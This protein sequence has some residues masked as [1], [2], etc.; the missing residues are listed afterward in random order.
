MQIPKELHPFSV[1]TMIVVTDNVHAKY[2]LAS[3]REID[4]IN[5]V[6]TKTDE[7]EQEREAVK[8]SS[9]GMRSGEPEDDRQEWSRK[10]LYT[11]LNKD[12][13]LRLQKGEFKQLAFTVPH[14]HVNELKESLHIDLLKASVAFVP[15]NLAGDE[16]TDIIAHVQQEI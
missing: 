1:P 10:Q 14:E 11:L 8:L 6:S 15:K 5:T 9:G 2:F 7:M 12:L 13:H 3:D 16:L 4:L